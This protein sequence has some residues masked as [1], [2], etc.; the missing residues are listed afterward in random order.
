MPRQNQGFPEDL[1]DGMIARA[2]PMPSDWAALLDCNRLSNGQ[3]ELS[4]EAI[5]WG[6]A[7]SLALQRRLILSSRTPGLIE[8]EIERLMPGPYD[9]RHFP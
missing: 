2:W 7:K 1:A 4:T 6:G 9:V 3:R 5:V 8:Q